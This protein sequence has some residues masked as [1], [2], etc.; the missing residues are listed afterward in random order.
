MN[1]IGTRVREARLARRPQWSLEELSQALLQATQLELA[2]SALSKIETGQRGVYDYEVQAFA[3]TL[4]V[5]VEWLLNGSG[6]S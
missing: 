6:A 3:V 2:E 5:S 4:G 1:L